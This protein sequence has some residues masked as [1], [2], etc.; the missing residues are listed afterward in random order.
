MNKNLSL[1]WVKQISSSG[2]PEPPPQMNQIMTN[3]N[4]QVFSNLSPI[5]IIP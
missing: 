3:M 1:I 4:I 2:N 5:I